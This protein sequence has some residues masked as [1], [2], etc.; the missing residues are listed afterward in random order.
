MFT[1]IP[2]SNQVAA[3][4]DNIF[5]IEDQSLTDDYKAKLWLN[6]KPLTRQILLIFLQ[7]KVTATI[8]DLQN[9]ETLVFTAVFQRFE[10]LQIF[11]QILNFD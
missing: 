8:A 11:T 2:S 7:S 4:L 3:V 1:Q 5:T 6:L 10:I 9:L